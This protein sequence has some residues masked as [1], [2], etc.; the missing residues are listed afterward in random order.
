MCLDVRQNYCPVSV[1]FKAFCLCKQMWCSVPTF[2][3]SGQKQPQSNGLI[4]KKFPLSFCC[5]L[6][7]LFRHHMGHL[8]PPENKSDTQLSFSGWDHWSVTIWNFFKAVEE[9]LRTWK[10]SSFEL[11]GTWGRKR[12]FTMFW[13]LSGWRSNR[14]V[15]A[16][17]SI[18]Y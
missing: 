9:N 7:T 1:S 4:I 5:Q 16:S 3:G 10:C 17:S 11:G 15:P 12:K 13:S 6:D 14:C 18:Y 8:P 2:S